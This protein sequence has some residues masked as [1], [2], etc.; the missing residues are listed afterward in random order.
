MHSFEKYKIRCNSVNKGWLSPGVV[1][2]LVS[3]LLR[4]FFCDALLMKLHSRSHCN[5]QATGEQGIPQTS[6]NVQS[7]T[8]RKVEKFLNT[9][10]VSLDFFLD[11]PNKN[12]K[13]FLLSKAYILL[14]KKIAKLIPN[15]ILKS[16]KW[17]DLTRVLHRKVSAQVFIMSSLKALFSKLFVGLLL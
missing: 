14:N 9:W 2:A 3:S 1:H 11:R 8:Q 15:S 16:W 7:T 6:A 17:L 12:R 10:N 5:T 4:K 13:K